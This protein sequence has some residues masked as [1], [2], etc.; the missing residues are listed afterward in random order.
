MSDGARY[1]SGANFPASVP[2]GGM[3]LARIRWD[4]VTKLGAVVAVL[5]VVVLWPRLEPPAPVVP[6]GAVRTLPAAGTSEAVTAGAA[7]KQRRRREREGPRRRDRPRRPP[8]LAAE[9]VAGERVRR[10]REH[11][12][13]ETGVRERV[14]QPTPAAPPTASIPSPPSPEAVAAAEFGVD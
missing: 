1:Q 9:P 13:G 6:D 11:V 7:P 10:P 12:A 5:A 8:P 14:R 4:N 3:D 2:S